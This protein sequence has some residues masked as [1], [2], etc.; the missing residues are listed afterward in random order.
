MT[1]LSPA[2]KPSRHSNGNMMKRLVHFS[3]LICLLLLSHLGW[4][5]VSA[6]TVNY[7]VTYD[8]NTNRYTAWV[9]PRYNVPNVTA[10]INNTAAT[11]FGGTAQFTLKVPTSFS[12]VNI[13]DVNGN[14]EKNPL[15]LGPGAPG[16]TWSN[17]DPN[18][19]YFVIGKSA[20]E[21]NY[22]SFRTGVDVPLF[23]FQGGGCFGVVSP[24]PP[25]DAFIAAADQVASLNVANSF[26][27]RSG[28][29]AGGNVVPL[30][31]F[32]NITGTPADCRPTVP[33]V[34]IRIQKTASVPT[35]QTVAVGTLVQF[36]VVA[37]NL[38]PDAATGLVVTDMAPA[39][40]QFVSTTVTQGNYNSATGLWTVGSL[41]ST[42]SATLVM[43]VRLTSEGVAYNQ[44]S[45][46]RLDQTDSIPDN[47]TASACVSVPVALCQ[48]D[49]VNLS[50]PS[51]FQGIQWYRN[52]QLIPNA[53]SNALLTSQTGTYTFQVANNSC[54]ST[55][56]CPVIVVAG[57]CCKPVCIPFVVTKTKKG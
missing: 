39:G 22:G 9:V 56:C 16:Q 8:V 30:E 28:Q 17:L 18:F 50:I 15:R 48:D 51:S 24:L 53:T 14:W 34:N 29:S 35:N 27:S 2:P 52:G 7:K 46:T 20:T 4:G 41:S 49:Q 54:P 32:V 21:T 11:E 26:Y 45:V 42:G 23:T 19:N 44:A 40:T 5:Q 31:Q 36:T 47:N 12:V 1:G 13:Q 33:V 43:S 6:N 38:G 3:F 55:G 57:N 10:P 25:G 37:S